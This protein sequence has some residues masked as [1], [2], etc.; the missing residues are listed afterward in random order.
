MVLVIMLHPSSP[1]HLLRSPRQRR[2]VLLSSLLPRCCSPT[3]HRSPSM[4]WFGRRVPRT[5][6]ATLV[7]WGSKVCKLLNDAIAARTQQFRGRTGSRLHLVEAP[8]LEARQERGRAR[9]LKW[10]ILALGF[11]E[12]DPLV[13]ST[14]SPSGGL[15]AGEGVI[16]LTRSLWVLLLLPPPPPHDPLMQI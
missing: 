5:R 13:W 11:L 8:V 9:W 15:A 4:A 14:S 1:L 10:W 12:V 6:C 3:L 16:A 2:I 7:A